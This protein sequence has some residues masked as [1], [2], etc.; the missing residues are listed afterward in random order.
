MM[1]NGNLTFT[2]DSIKLVEVV[3]DSPISNTQSI[4]TLI[5]DK[6]GKHYISLQKWWRE[7]KETPW[8]EGKGFHFEPAEAKGAVEALKKALDALT[9]MD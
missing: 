2:D 3:A 9:R 4:K 5:I 7:A 1:D 8:R 6:N